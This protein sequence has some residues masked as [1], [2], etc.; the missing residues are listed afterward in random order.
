MN[1]IIRCTLGL[2]MF[3]ASSAVGGVE[4]LDETFD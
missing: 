3:A 1:T 2:S 4:F